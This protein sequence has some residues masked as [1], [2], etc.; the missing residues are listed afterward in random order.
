MLSPS[1]LHPVQF[2]FSNLKKVYKKCYVRDIMMLH[3]LE[4]DLNMAN[5][6]N[7]GK[8]SKY[9][10]FSKFSQIQSLN[11]ELFLSTWMLVF[12]VIQLKVI[13][14]TSTFLHNKCYV[15]SSREPFIIGKKN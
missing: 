9:G 14:V 6:L 10:K 13:G 1:W 2:Q 12:L 11:P 5:Y 4:N 8:L 15:Q 3:R 7:M